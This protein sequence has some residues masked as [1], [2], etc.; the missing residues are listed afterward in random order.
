MHCCQM[1]KKQQTDC[2]LM[3]AEL[4]VNGVFNTFVSA[5]P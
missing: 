4:A 5:K 2:C 3:R 1:I